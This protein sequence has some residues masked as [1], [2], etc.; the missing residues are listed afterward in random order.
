LDVLSSRLDWLEDQFVRLKDF[1]ILF[2]CPG[3]FELYTDSDS[4][5][6]IVEFLTRR[7]KIQLVAVTLIDC[8]TCVSS[9]AF[10]SAVLLSLSMMIQLELPHVN[11]LSKMDTMRRI[12]PEMAFN[13][14]YFLK[15]GDGNL[16][17]L[18][19]K[20]FPAEEC[21]PTL[22]L[23]ISYAKFVKA[24]SQVTEDFSL[25]S[26]VPLAIEDKESAIHVLSVCDKANGYSFSAEGF[27]L[28]DEACKEDSQPVNEYYT[29][30]EEKFKQGPFCS[31]CGADAMGKKLLR[32]S[33][34]RKVEYCSRDCQKADWPIHKRVCN[35]QQQI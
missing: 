13:L 35:Y 6:K 32:C 20:L 34:C 2:D 3:Q 4:M 19:H 18:V 9:H 21:G 31:S 7:M 17:S 26:F 16:E 5:K 1:Y 30:L 27:N 15:A 10:I 12:S 33:A 14:E 25:V 23:D 29:G 8:L 28:L 22:P 24:I 11:L